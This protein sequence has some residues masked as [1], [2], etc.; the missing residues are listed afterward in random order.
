MSIPTLLGAPYDAASSFL[1]GAARAPDAI[2]VAFGSD[3]A[4]RWTERLTDLD[5]AGVFADAGNATIGEHP[6]DDITRAVARI[7]TQGGR[8]LVLGGDHAI[9]H[10]VVRAVANIQ[11][12]LSILH[13]DAHNDLYDV[14]DGDRSSHACPFARI[15]EEGLCAQ[16]VQIG[17]RAMTG[18]QRAQAD[19]FGVEVLDMARWRRGDRFALK[20]PVYISVDLDAL[21]PAFAPGVSHR[22][23]GGLSVR[24]I[25][26]VLHGIDQPI[27][28]ADLVEYNPL[29]DMHE[30]TSLVGAKLLKE[31][32]DA[33][34]RS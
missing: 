15:L 11:R 10:P 8:P 6:F 23:P 2:R 21:D 1:R 28:G 22:E 7:L 20:H 30:M 19:R 9:T 18:H 17:I 5:Q 14:Y 31:L 13:F 12:P 24:D 16:L 26:T 29:R 33:M 32:I 3:A 27:I 4:N 25:I 34:H